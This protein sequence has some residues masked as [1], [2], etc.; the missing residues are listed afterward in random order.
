MDKDYEY[1]CR[2]K[3]ICILGLINK[4]Y[5]SSTILY[6]LA[7]HYGSRILEVGSGTGSGI[8]GAFP[9]RVFGLDINQY[10]V[11]YCLEKGYRAGMIGSD[12]RFPAESDSFDVCVLDNVLE[13]IAEPALTLDECARVT[14]K[15]G[16]LLVVVPGEKGYACD[17]DHKIYYDAGRLQSLDQRWQL[18]RLFSLPFIFRSRLLSSFFASYCLVA[19][20]KKR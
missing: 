6:L 8:L 15:N 16:G 17:D 1:F 5:I 20:Y 4:R 2:L 9:E 11:D 19:E 10:A 18:K 12:G 14:G 7:R 13:H 3:N